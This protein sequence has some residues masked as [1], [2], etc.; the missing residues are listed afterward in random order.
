MNHVFS[1]TFTI[2]IT[3][4]FGLTHVQK[5]SLNI[6]SH[7][8]PPPPSPLTHTYPHARTHAVIKLNF[9]YSNTGTSTHTYIHFKERKK[10]VVRERR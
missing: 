8:T 4:I 5:H 1:Y 9:S 7:S 3:Y 10:D 2:I 6:P